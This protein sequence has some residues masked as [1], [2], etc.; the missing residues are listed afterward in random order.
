MGKRSNKGVIRPRDYWPTV[1]PDAFIPLVP[2]I[3]GMA[4][5]EPCYGAGDLEDGFRETAICRWRSDIEPQVR[6]VVQQDATTLTKEDLQDCNL[7]VTN[8]PFSW[9]MLKPLLDHLP[10]LKPTWLLL[11]ADFMHNKRSAPYILNCST[12]V[13]V[14]RL[15]WWLGD[16]GN[17][18]Q[19]G[20]K[21]K[22]NYCWY[23]FHDSPQDY[24][25]FIPRL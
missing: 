17:P 19:N 24:T 3:R 11:P 15:Y 5:A 16:D 20:I 23:L 22:D 6:G 12:I 9:E 13:A 2:F 14:R 21:G 1:D 18:T 7:I 10:T 25:K 8:P 4:Y